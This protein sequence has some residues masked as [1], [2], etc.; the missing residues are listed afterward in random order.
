M[1]VAVLVSLE[2]VV[3]VSVVERQAIECGRCEHRMG[4]EFIDDDDEFL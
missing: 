1:T 2:S 3:T 4:E